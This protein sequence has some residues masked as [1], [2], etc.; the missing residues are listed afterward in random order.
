MSD[1]KKELI[2]MA[3]KKLGKSW[4]DIVK[5]ADEDDKK[6]AKKGDPIAK[7]AKSASK[8]P[9]KLFKESMTDLKKKSQK[10]S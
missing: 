6:Q 2:E 4:K 10:K 9:K 5:Q 3:E 8:S 1:W 7:A